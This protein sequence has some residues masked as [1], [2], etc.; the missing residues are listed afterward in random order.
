MSCRF[1]LR[2]RR[3][4]ERVDFPLLYTRSGPLVRLSFETFVNM[5][6]CLDEPG[7]GEIK[8]IV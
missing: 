3:E 1:F 7:G 6:R 8:N 4:N 2:I 5:C